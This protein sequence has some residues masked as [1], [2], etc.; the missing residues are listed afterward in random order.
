MGSNYFLNDPSWLHP[1]WGHWEVLE[2]AGPMCQSGT[3]WQCPV[4]AWRKTSLRWRPLYIRWSYLS[5]D[6]NLRCA[7]RQNKDL[8]KKDTFLRTPCTPK[9]TPLQ[10]EHLSKKPK[11]ISNTNIFLKIEPLNIHNTSTGSFCF[12][13]IVSLCELYIG[14]WEQFD[15]I[16]W[17]ICMFEN[18][19]DPNIWELRRSCS[20]ETKPLPI[21]KSY[22][23]APAGNRTQGLWFNVPVL[24]PL[25]YWDTLRTCQKF[26][27]FV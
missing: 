9:Y 8:P 6:T 3:M 1:T 19:E 21:T 16:R 18:S 27:Y 5:K 2:G 22:L 13:V 7:P 26:S 15:V 14:L 12:P 10:E 11:H 24:W 20:N 4:R 17:L 23:T 25:S